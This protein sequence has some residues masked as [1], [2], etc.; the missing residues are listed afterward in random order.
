MGGILKR[1][2][3]MNRNPEPKEEAILNIHIASAFVRDYAEKVFSKYRITDSQYNVLRILKGVYP[4]GHPRCEIIIR[5]IDRAP[6][7]TRLIDRLEKNGLALRDRSTEDR[8]HS[9][10]KIT[11]KGLKLLDDLQPDFEKLVKSL[12]INLTDNEWKRLSHLTEKIY[13]NYI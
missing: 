7:I 13:E 4:E 3:K 11:K 10:T 9:I 2:L 12:K 5:M 1:R 6:D 8:R